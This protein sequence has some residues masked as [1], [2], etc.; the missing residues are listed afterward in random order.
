[1]VR[2]N[3]L[4]ALATG[5]ART[6]AKTVEAKPKKLEKPTGHKTDERGSNWAFATFM[7]NLERGIT[8]VKREEDA[9]KRRADRGA[10][11]IPEKP[12]VITK[13]DVKHLL[14]SRR[15]FS[16]LLF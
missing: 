4:F 13:A 3:D 1:M 12:D 6:V 8:K 14:R 9:D 10:A 11:Q 7:R 5:Y 2:R 16:K 15:E